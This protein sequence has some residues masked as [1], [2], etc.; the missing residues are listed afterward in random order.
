MSDGKIITEKKGHVLLMGIDRVA[1]KNAFEVSMYIDLG[2]AYGILDRD[3]DLR[4]GVLYAKGDHF[5]AGLDLTQW[6]SHLSSGKFPEV[7][8]DACDPLGLYGKQVEKPVVM[9]VQGICLT[10]GLEL[11]LSTDIRVA[12]RSTRMGQ[13]EVKRGIYPA[14]GG[15]VRLIQEI[16]WSNAMRYLLTGDEITADDGYRMGL[17]QEVVDDG[18]QLERAIEIAEKIAD[19]APLGVVA[20]LKSARL[21]RSHGEPKAIEAL[22]P[23]LIPL[24]NSE[25]AK[26]G[27]QSFIERRKANFQGK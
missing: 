18:K 6:V 20:T 22:L 21:A 27:V 14:G 16:G 4:C 8:V 2:K 17:V 26:E 9:A 24:L 15:T 5:T 11:L 7:P 25:D 12:A 13:I 19:Q 23:G 1:K 3:N 10:I